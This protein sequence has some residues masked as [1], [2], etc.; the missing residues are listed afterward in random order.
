MNRKYVKTVDDVTE[1]L[2]TSNEAE[3]RGTSFDFFKI[4][5]AIF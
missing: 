2:S 1:M 5:L 4:F 3:V